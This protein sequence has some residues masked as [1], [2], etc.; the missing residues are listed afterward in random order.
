[1]DVLLHAKLR[2]VW[3]ALALYVLN[4]VVMVGIWELMNVMMG[5][6][7]VVMDAITIAMLN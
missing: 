4:H 7:L 3:I 1:M 5:I 6:Q 2:E